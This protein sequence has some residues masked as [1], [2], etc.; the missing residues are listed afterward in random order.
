MDNPIISQGLSTVAKLMEEKANMS[1]TGNHQLLQFIKKASLC[2]KNGD[3][4]ELVGKMFR[5]DDFYN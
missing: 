3:S 2:I 1:D 5:E 4:M